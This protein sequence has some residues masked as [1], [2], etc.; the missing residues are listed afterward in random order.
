MAVIAM[1]SARGSPG[2]TTSALALTLAW[3]RQVALAECDP[4]GGTVQAGYLAG[5]LP[6][7]RG[8]GELAVAELRGED[9]HRVWWAQLVD[10][11]P[12]N[13][14]RLLLPGIADPV[15]AGALQPVWSRLAGFFAGLAHVEGESGWDVIADC[16]RLAAAHTPWPLLTQADLLLLV[17]PAT[18]PGLSAAT[19]AV[20]M[21]RSQLEQAGSGLDRLG[22]LL[23]G[24]GDQTSRAVAHLLDT[25]VVA[26]LP[27]DARTAR[28]LSRGGTVRARSPLLAAAQLAGRELQRRAARLP[29]QPASTRGAR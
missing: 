25:R 2:V 5:G 18:L 16:G 19:P 29:A 22:L 24:R 13:R 10:L 7:D 17:L 3:R 1:C 8:I 12:P 15:Q 21:L 23:C 11:E 9:L 27:H 28:V 6:A 26:E 20:R 4:A 14:R